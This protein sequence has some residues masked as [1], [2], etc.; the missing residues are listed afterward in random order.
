MTKEI[1]LT[2]GKVA[3]VDDADYEALNQYKWCVAHGQT[4]G[5]YAVRAGLAR[6]GQRKRTI[7]MH[8]QIVG[9]A[10]GVDVDHANGNT[11]D[12]RRRN[13][14]EATRSQNCANRH[15]RPA[16][17]SKYRG[18]HWKKA[19]GKWAAQIKVNGHIRHLGLFAD[20]QEAAR[21]YDA[22]AR[23]VFGEYANP[24]FPQPERRA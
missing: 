15:K 8:R 3:L 6:D 24:N 20:E 17:S 13:L 9:A 14:R 12:N 2:R 11:L 1:Q 19:N 7:L 10:A 16:S 5:F 22:A 4:G 18:V 23:A 21:T